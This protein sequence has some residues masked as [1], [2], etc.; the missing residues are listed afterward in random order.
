MR[1]Y[2]SEQIQLTCA[3]CG[4]AS[5]HLWRGLCFSCSEAHRKA[6][7]I[8]WGLVVVLALGAL[9]ALLLSQD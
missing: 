5:G 9:A 7:V 1:D 4:Q 6:S 3:E 2:S 8:G